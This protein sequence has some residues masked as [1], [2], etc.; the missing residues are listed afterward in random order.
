MTYLRSSAV[1]VPLRDENQIN[2]HVNSARCYP[3]AVAYYMTADDISGFPP[4]SWLDREYSVVT[5]IRGRSREYLNSPNSIGPQILANDIE[6]S[7]FVHQNPRPGALYRYTLWAKSSGG[8]DKRICG[9][10]YHFEHLPSPVGLDVRVFPPS[11][12][13]VG[14]RFRVSIKTDVKFLKRGLEWIIEQIDDLNIRSVYEKY[15]NEDQKRLND[16]IAFRV[17]RYDK[18]SGDF[19]NLGIHTPGTFID[20]ATA[21][22]YRHSQLIAG[23]GY[24]Y[25]FQLCMTSLPGLLS[26]GTVTVEKE[27]QDP[28]T[29]RLYAENLYKFTNPR[30]IQTRT[31]LLESEASSIEGSFLEGRTS[32]FINKDITLA[33][34]VYKIKN[35]NVT[36]MGMDRTPVIS[37]EC[38]ATN[39]DYFLIMGEM[40]NVKAPIGTV[41]AFSKNNKYSFNDTTLGG[42]VG[43]RSYCVRM[44]T[45][46]QKLG[47]E[48]LWV[49]LIIRSNLNLLEALA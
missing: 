27:T 19:A 10:V 39:V 28:E 7:T 35:V 24:R 29:L 2:I 46:D 23:R 37:W 43:Q 45:L 16:I 1:V 47:P 22:G 40:G 30:T 6:N 9:E 17:S 38:S 41:H 31:L 12:N 20:D 14:N 18:V 44:V 13:R 15:F 5:V 11:M 33:S 42:V 32:I 3:A 4:Q 34:S 48:S 25:V 8:Y 49:K 26:G 21:P 36:I